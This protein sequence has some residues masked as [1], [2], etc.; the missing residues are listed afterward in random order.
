MTH[1]IDNLVVEQNLTQTSLAATPTITATANGTLAL[2]AASTAYQVLTGT[3]PS[4]VVRLPNATT[5]ALGQCYEIYNAATVAVDVQT[6][7][8][9]ALVS[10]QPNQQVSFRCG[11]TST[12]S[13]TW[14]YTTIEQSMSAAG[15]LFCSYPGTGLDI[16]YTAG[17]VFINGSNVE[18]AEGVLTLAA[19]ITDGYI[20]VDPVDEAVSFGETLPNNAVGLAT[21]TTTGSAVTA[22]DDIREFAAKNLVWGITADIEPQ[23]SQSTSAGG[24]LEKYARADHVHAMN[25]NLMKVGTVAAASFTGSPKSYAVAFSEAFTDTGYAV[26][27]K[28]VDV[29][30]WSYTNKATTGFTIV[31]NASQALTGEVSWVAVK[32]GEAT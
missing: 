5:L 22:L 25:V 8:A 4:Q 21:F 28:G 13:G 32:T 14:Y 17:N 27:I 2:T 16:N 6:A 15:E 3:N 31:T 7:T 20:Y 9:A 11:N 1:Y 30:T 12:A 23:D 18:L 29:R 26:D 24:S 10:I 19:D